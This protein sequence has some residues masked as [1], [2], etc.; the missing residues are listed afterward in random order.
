MED[1]KS[2]LK[3][4]VKDSVCGIYC[5][6]NVENSKKYVG[7]SKNIYKRIYQ[8]RY[9]I[10]NDRYRNENEYFRNSVKKY[11]VEC[12]KY[13]VLEECT[14]PETSEREL[15]WMDTLGTTN[16]DKGFNLRRDSS[17]GMV[18]S[19]ET[20]L[21]I[22]ERLKREW[23]QG[24]RDGHSEKLKKRWAEDPE[25]VERQGR[26]F[27]KYKTK[28]YYIIETDGVVESGLSYK[29]LK[30]RGFVSVLSNFHRSKSDRVKFKNSIVT[31][32][33]I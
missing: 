27:T 25:R 10:L 17:T 11:G 12:F 15:Y 33:K 7:K 8:H 19:K 20:S 28:Y 32:I 18:T 13:Y 5:I 3:P 23:S 16:R 9:D 22:S 29:D 21:K 31:R 2:V 24:L 30:I 14:I 26:M 1:L 6:V 4:D